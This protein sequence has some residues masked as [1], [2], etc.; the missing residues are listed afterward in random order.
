VIKIV[1]ITEEAR[2][3]GPLKRIHQVAEH[4]QSKGVSTTV[5]FPKKNSEDFYRALQ[6]S[7]V[8]TKRIALTRLT[9]EKSTLLWYAIS[10]IPQ[11]L[12]LIF[13]IRKEKYDIVLCNGSW[14]IKGVL[15]SKFTKAK[16]IW[17][18]NDSQQAGMVEKLFSIASMWSDAFVFVSERTKDYYASINPD[19]LNKPHTIIQS[20]IDLDHFSAG[21]AK[22]LS[23]DKFNVLTVGYI[24]PNKGL[25]TFIEAVNLVN[26]NKEQIQFYIAGP[27]FKSQEAYK[28]KLQ[29]LIDKYQ[30]DNIEFLGMRK[31]IVDLLRSAD[32]YVCSSDF[33]ASPI[34]VWEALATGCPVLSTDVGDVKTVF[35]NNECGIVVSAQD[36]HAMAVKLIN[37]VTDE[38][39]RKKLS[40]KARPT[41]EKLFSLAFTAKGYE[42]FYHKVHNSNK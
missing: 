20:P 37:L 24:N 11:V 28:A 42:E 5:L 13:I 7:K 25:E 26:K 38:K 4:L 16:S 19:I 27:V 6:K 32:L 34:A 23:K 41:A 30:I 33:E 8:P 40:E 39:L 1:N 18:Q 35:E 36:P 29:A 12:R 17:I 3:G 9:K 15:A 2:G 22:L 10:F 14:Q 21:E 31:D